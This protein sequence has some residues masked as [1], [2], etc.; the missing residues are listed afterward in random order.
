VRRENEMMLDGIE[1]ENKIKLSQKEF[2]KGRILSIDCM[3]GVAMVLVFLQHSYQ[4]AN[5]QIIPT[6]IDLLLW[7][8]T[9]LAAVA[10]VA[11]S[12]TVYSFFLYSQLDWKSAYRHYGV[13]NALIIFAAHPA[14]CLT[15][16]LFRMPANVG[17]QGPDAF[18][19][20]LQFPIT[21]TIALC[22]LVSPILIV[23]LGSLSRC[24]LI[25]GILVV[26]IAARAF[27]LPSNPLLFI[28]KEAMF[29]GLAEP[30]IFW[31]PVLPWL[32]IFLTGSYVGQALCEQR[33]GRLELCLIVRRLNWAGGILAVSC[34]LLTVGYKALK[35]QFLNKWSPNIFQAI[36]PSQTTTLLP[37][38]LA[39][40]VWL[41][42]VFIKRVDIM[43]RYD[44]PA[45]LLA[46]FGRTSLFTYVIQ[47]AI[48]ESIPASLGL[49]GTLSLEG[50]VSLFIVGMLATGI[51]SYTYGRLSGKIEQFDSTKPGIL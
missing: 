7:E 46:I 43:G 6:R 12:G 41:L 47:F 28:L 40:L 10:F 30:K 2:T 11:I 44:R 9:G 38:Y 8:T 35:M 31:F 21:D 14:I 34:V 36:Y 29:G 48:V 1:K 37:G 16:F 22:M 33:K 19:V 17:H 27:I 20:Q 25:L 49:K 26:D 50:F 32:A 45:W 15:S 4:S 5:Y 51:V 13:Q 39:V 23:H 24:V 42:A 18:Q 3:R